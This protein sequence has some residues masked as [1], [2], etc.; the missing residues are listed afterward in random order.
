MQ[1][2]SHSHGSCW[3]VGESLQQKLC[4]AKLTILHLAKE[5]LLS[6]EEADSLTH[7]ILLNSSEEEELLNLARDCLADFVRL[8]TFV[9]GENDGEALDDLTNRITLDSGSLA[10]FNKRVT[11]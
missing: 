8:E 10:L 9:Q 5:T 11:R 6:I 4:T 7:R 3:Q 1:T 2:H